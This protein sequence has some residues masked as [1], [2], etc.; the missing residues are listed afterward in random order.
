MSV[1]EHSEYFISTLVKDLKELGNLLL[2]V[3]GLGVLGCQ[4]EVGDVRQLMGVLFEPLQPI[5]NASLE[6][7]RILY[8]QQCQ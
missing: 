5:I 2:M 6:S 1:V 8:F 7:G 4:Q 3:L